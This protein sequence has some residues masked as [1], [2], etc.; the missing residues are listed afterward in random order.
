MQQ[1]IEHFRQQQGKFGFFKKVLDL[2]GQESAQEERERVHHAQLSRAERE[3]VAL[4]GEIKQ[5]RQRMEA[6]AGAKQQVMHLEAQLAERFV[7]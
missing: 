4:R 3:A 2:F 5:I 6:A 7:R 1:F